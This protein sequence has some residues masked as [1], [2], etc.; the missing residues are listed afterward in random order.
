MCAH[1]I[2]YTRLRVILRLKIEKLRNIINNILICFN[3][4]L[5]GYVIMGLLQS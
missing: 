3:I 5:L 2:L 4:F 1:Y